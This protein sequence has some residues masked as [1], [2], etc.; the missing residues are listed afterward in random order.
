MPL[1]ATAQDLAELAAQE[2]RLVFSGF[3]HDT[4]WALGT[5]LVTAARAAA[6]PVV[7]SISS[8]GQ[9]LFHAALPGTVPDN[10]SWVERKVRVVLRFGH[11][12]LYVGTQARLAGSTFEER[13]GLPPADYAAHGGSFPITVRGVGVVGAVTVS[14]LPQVEDHAF[15]VDQLTRFL[16]G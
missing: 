12:S 5:R 15:V 2:E 4:A 3:D 7:V 1:P 14:G 13:T 8:G 11:S 6:L 10:D 16:A 9:R